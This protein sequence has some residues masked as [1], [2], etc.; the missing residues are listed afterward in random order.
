MDK[1]AIGQE[2]WQS[3]PKEF[4]YIA[5]KSNVQDTCTSLYARSIVCG[6]TIPKIFEGKV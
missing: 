3:R 1:Y 4:I 6:L 2:N 5:R